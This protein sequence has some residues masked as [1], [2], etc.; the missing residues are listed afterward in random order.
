MAKG[1]KAAPRSTWGN[2]RKSTQNTWKKEKRSVLGADM[3]KQEADQFRTLCKSSGVSVSSALSVFV[4]TAI[5]AGTLDIIRDDIPWTRDDDGTTAAGSRLGDD[6]R[7]DGD[8]FTRDGRA[9]GDSCRDDPPGQKNIDP[10]FTQGDQASENDTPGSVDL[11]TANDT[12]G[13]VD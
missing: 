9:A 3:P 1:Q 13:T 11:P 4:R 2:E 12:P 8:D 6:G 7:R 5:H 10:D